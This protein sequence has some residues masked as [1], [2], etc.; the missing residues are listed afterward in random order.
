LETVA[1]ALDRVL[2][3]DS[4]LG[5]GDEYRTKLSDVVRYAEELKVELIAGHDL[6]PEAQEEVRSHLATQA[7]ILKGLSS[8]IVRVLQEDDSSGVADLVQEASQVGYILLQLCQYRLDFLTPS[9][10]EVLRPKA[11]ALHLLE[12]QASQ[13]ISWDRERKRLEQLLSLAQATRTLIQP[14]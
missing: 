4:Y 12:V 6:A 9:L 5:D 3:H 1:R 11:R 13:E 8:R 7:R 10:V 14:V 2:S